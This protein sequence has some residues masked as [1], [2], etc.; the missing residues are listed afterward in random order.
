MPLPSVYAEPSSSVVIA[1]SVC[2]VIASLSC[3]ESTLQ[4]KDRQERKD[5]LFEIGGMSKFNWRDYDS[6]ESELDE[7]LAEIVDWYAQECFGDDDGASGDEGEE[8]GDEGEEGG[9]EGGDEDASQQE[10]PT[11]EVPPASPEDRQSV[12]AAARRGRPAP[13]RSIS[14]RPEAGKK[15]KCLVDGCT[16]QDNDKYTFEAHVHSAHGKDKL[17]KSECCD[18]MSNWRENIP[19][20]AHKCV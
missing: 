13:S 6:D 1:C 20:G 9:D 12:S 10:V 7:E 8:G 5:R 17:F 19:F 2:V 11:E 14:P 16:Y 15:Y 18:F 4:E 3:G